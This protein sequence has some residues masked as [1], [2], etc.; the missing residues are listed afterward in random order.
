LVLDGYGLGKDDP[1]ANP[2][3]ASNPK[4]F[5]D[6]IEDSKKKS[7]YK[8]IRAHGPAVGLP[9][10]SDMGNSE[11]GHN[12]LGAGQIYEQG[13]A[14]VDKAFETGSIFASDNWKQVIE[15]TAK[16]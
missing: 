6:I 5:N 12:A 1:K 13:T 11:V 14:L 4:Y 2:I 10:E 7:L 3:I 9:S 8:V 15:G 16:V